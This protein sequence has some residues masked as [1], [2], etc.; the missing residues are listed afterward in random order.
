MEI[1]FRNFW[2]AKS[3]KEHKVA[4]CGLYWKVG[5]RTKAYQCM[6]PFEAS[7]YAMFN[8][9]IKRTM[10]KLSSLLSASV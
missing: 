7:R 3:A 8:S 6:A 10:E 9:R 4:S 1:Y 5:E 2:A